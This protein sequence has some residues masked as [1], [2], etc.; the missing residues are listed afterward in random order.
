MVNLANKTNAG[1]IINPP[2]APTKPV[3]PPTPDPI[4]INRLKFFMLFD[5]L[6]FLVLGFFIIRTKDKII[7]MLK[8]SINPISFVMSK[9]SK[10]RRMS[11]IFGIKNRRVR[12][13]DTSA[14][15]VNTAA[16]LYSISF[17]FILMSAPIADENPTTNME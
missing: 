15:S 8:N 12:D 16:V 9:C 5:I 13:T 2:P 17:F 7:T 14:G 10:D 4:K 6:T 11:G 3:K 1:T